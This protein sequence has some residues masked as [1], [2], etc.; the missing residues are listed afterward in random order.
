MAPLHQSPGSKSGVRGVVCVLRGRSDDL[1]AS[2]PLLS[3]PESPR[4]VAS[5]LGRGTGGAGPDGSGSASSD[6]FS[7]VC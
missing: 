1:R 2:P 3:P 6:P 5:S 4:A 7:H